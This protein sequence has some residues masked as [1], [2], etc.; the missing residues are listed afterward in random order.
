MLV[1]LVCFH[2]GHLFSDFG[3]F[4]VQLGKLYWVEGVDFRR[5]FKVNKNGLSLGH[6]I[7]IKS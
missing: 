5:A 4:S 7:R 1:I 6:A 2:Y 3:K